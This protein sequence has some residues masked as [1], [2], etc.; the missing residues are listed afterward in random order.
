MCLDEIPCHPQQPTAHHGVHSVVI[1]QL[2][3]AFAVNAGGIRIPIRPPSRFSDH[4]IQA[5]T[6][7][8][9]TPTNG[10]RQNKVSGMCVKHH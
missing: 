3:L 4:A 2:N 8:Q 7:R 5:N 6:I 10:S 9:K 1:M